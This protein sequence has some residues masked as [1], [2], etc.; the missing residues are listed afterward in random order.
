MVKSV[1]PYYNHPWLA[2]ALLWNTW[3]CCFAQIYIELR[4]DQPGISQSDFWII[5]WRFVEKFNFGFFMRSG[6]NIY[7]L[8]FLLVFLRK[9][10]SRIP[11]VCPSFHEPDEWNCWV[12]WKYTNAIF[13]LSKISR[14]SKYFPFITFSVRRQKIEF[15]K[16]KSQYYIIRKRTFAICCKLA[17]RYSWIFFF[18]W[19]W[20]MVCKWDNCSIELPSLKLKII[21]K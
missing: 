19:A 10:T 3:N 13:M 4:Q 18:D 7:F 14:V 11:R 16:M 9:R 5:T 21:R 2:V 8:H 20:S 1:S 15:Q 12:H 6:F 17:S